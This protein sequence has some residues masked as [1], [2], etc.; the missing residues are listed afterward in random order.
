MAACH[1]LHDDCLAK[2]LL[3]HGQ[4]CRVTAAAAH[5]TK[6]VHLSKLS[7]AGCASATAARR[8]IGIHKESTMESWTP[9]VAIIKLPW[10]TLRTD[11]GAVGGERKG[12][13]LRRFLQSRV[14]TQCLTARRRKLQKHR[15]Q[16]KFLTAR[17]RKLQKHRRRDNEDDDEDDNE[18][19]KTTTALFL[20]QLRLAP[21]TTTTST[22]SSWRSVLDGTKTTTARH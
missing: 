15:R 13:R 21:R 7:T 19:T 11:A 6:Y 5:A 8:P 4:Q 10:R 16:R 1:V 14:S 18:T 20:F 17:R 9:S 3:V 2:L 12:R 22:T